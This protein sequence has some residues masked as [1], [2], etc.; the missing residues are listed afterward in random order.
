MV[1]TMAQAVAAQ[2]LEAEKDFQVYMR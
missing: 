1:E 2:M